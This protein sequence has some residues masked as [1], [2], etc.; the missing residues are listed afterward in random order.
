[1][2]GIVVKSV[3]RGDGED[4]VYNETVDVSGDDVATGIDVAEETKSRIRS[5]YVC[6]WLHDRVDQLQVAVDVRNVCIVSHPRF[7]EAENV[8]KASHVI[9]I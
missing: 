2:V 5:G 9:D 1:M 8:L 4:L 7:A 6:Q 3:Q